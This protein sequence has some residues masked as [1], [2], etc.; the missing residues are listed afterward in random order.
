M[1]GSPFRSFSPKETKPAIGERKNHSSRRL[2]RIH[3]FV[4]RRPGAR[5]QFKL[6]SVRGLTAPAGDGD[7]VQR[8]SFSNK[9]S[10]LSRRDFRIDQQSNSIVH[11]LVDRRAER[12]S[13]LKSD[14]RLLVWRRVFDG[15]ETVRGIPH[16]WRQNCC[17]PISPLISV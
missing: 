15:G 14:A 10:R 4:G 12:L 5:R 7:F 1:V 9:G 11:G 3:D 16:H 2:Y 17:R 8:A 6:S 13:S